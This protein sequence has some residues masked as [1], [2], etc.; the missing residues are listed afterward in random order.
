MG[1]GAGITLDDTVPL[2]VWFQLSVGK[3]QYHR[4]GTR[5]EQAESMDGLMS[6]KRSIEIVL[7]MATI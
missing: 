5:L 1:A 2:D 4:P 7:F 3:T 6:S